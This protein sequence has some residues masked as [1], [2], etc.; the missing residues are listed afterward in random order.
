VP[1]CHIFIEHQADQRMA[2]R[3]VEFEECSGTCYC[4][5]LM[6]LASYGLC[7]PFGYC[8]ASKFM[9]SQQ[10][11]IDDKR[12]NYKSDCW[13]V[14][15]DKMV[16]LERIQ[17]VNITQDCIA[18]ACGI[19][20]ISIQ[21]AGGGDKAEVTIVAPKNPQ[22]LRDRIM[23]TRDAFVHGSGSHTGDSALGD[24]RGASVSTPL[25]ASR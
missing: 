8:V 9:G 15:T 18:R 23:A 3:G 20:N 17:D 16:P 25:L 5:T 13:F 4:W 2:D 7:L 24:V 11:H 12:I 19:S 10:V 6:S 14:R 1:F 22:Q 21:T